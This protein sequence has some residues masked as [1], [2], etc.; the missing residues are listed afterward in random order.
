MIAKALQDQERAFMLLNDLAGCARQ[1]G[2]P[3][4]NFILCP[5]PRAALKIAMPPLCGLS[6]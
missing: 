2:I 3:C 4:V 1:E 5:A 6:A